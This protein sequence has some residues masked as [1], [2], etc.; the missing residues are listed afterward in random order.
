MRDTSKQAIVFALFGGILI[1]LGVFFW[2]SG[3]LEI[4]TN[5]QILN[6]ESEIRSSRKNQ[7][8]TKNERLKTNINIATQ[9]ELEA[10]PRIGEVTARK[11]MGGRPYVN[12]R[13][14]VE[15]KILGEKAYD[16]IRDLIAVE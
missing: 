13:E 4:N 9:V 10:L 16:E 5:I 3:G 14:L 1:G 15:R 12:T 2:K 11:I 6:Y 8:N 7:I